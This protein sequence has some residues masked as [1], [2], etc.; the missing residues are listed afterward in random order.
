MRG[1]VGE[2]TQQWLW[3]NQASTQLIHY[4]KLDVF[5]ESDQRGV[6]SPPFKF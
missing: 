2:N 6:L 5:A 3:K 1:I 4:S